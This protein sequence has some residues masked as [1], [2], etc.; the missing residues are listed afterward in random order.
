MRESLV[1]LQK[2]LGGRYGLERQI[3]RGAMA[4]VYLATDRETG[5]KVALK[6]LR[7]ELIAVLGPGRFRREIEILRRLQHPNIVPVLDA[8]EAGSVL[9][10]VM[11]YFAGDTL[12]S[13]LE[14]QGSLTLS[15]MLAILQDLAE[16]IDYAHSRQVIHRDLKPE[17]ILFDDDRA[18]VCDFGIARAIESAAVESFS[19]SGLVLGTPGYMSPEQATAGRV[20]FRCD[21][22]ALGCLAYEMLLGDPPFTGPTAQAVLAKVIG[23]SPPAL[24]TARPELPPSVEDAIL[25]ALARAPEKRPQSAGHFFELVSVEETR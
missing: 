10:Y 22:Y 3:G 9:F 5:G 7:R 17:N 16:A 14:R 6:V 18:L 11:P 8:D 20:D 2:A 23:S 12:R 21:I 15:Q 1:E 24:R 4:T 25:C 19:S 13:R